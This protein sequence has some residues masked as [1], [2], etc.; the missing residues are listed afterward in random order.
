MTNNYSPLRAVAKPQDPIGLERDLQE[1]LDPEDGWRGFDVYISPCTIEASNDPFTAEEIDAMKV[2]DQDFYGRC[3]D[4]IADFNTTG[5][6]QLDTTFDYEL[7]Y[8]IGADFTKTL[9]ALQ[10]SMLEHVASMVGLSD[11]QQGR[12]LR[13]RR[14]RLRQLQL[15]PE[16]EFSKIEGVS[17]LPLDKKDPYWGKHV[18][19][20][21]QLCLGFRLW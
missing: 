16:P 7:H 21:S 15:L 20:L 1:Y 9:A 2:C 3:I 19:V 4:N 14:V 13:N 6:L 17:S 8:Q 11:C 18:A 5:L 12:N 10:A